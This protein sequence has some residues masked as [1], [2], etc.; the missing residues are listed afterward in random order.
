MK[1]GGLT[2]LPDAIRSR[3]FNIGVA[4]GVKE[5]SE[6]RAAA[7]RWQRVNDA[8]SYSVPED[9]SPYI[10]RINGKNYLKTSSA[11]DGSDRKNDI[12]HYDS[13]SSTYYVI[14]IEEASSSSKLSKKSNNNYA[15]QR[16]KIAMEEIVNEITK[17]VGTG[18]SYSTLATKHFLEKMNIEYHDDVVYNYFKTTYPELFE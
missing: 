17:V 3:L 15:G 13:S 18:E 5:T 4:N 14:Q 8:W 10:A 2:D 12:L 7:D 11:V 1:N 6:A 9:E 16:G